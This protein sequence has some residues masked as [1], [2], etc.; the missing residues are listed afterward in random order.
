M[1]CKVPPEMSLRC[2]RSTPR[3]R[4]ARYVSRS[5][6]SPPSSLLS[7]AN[8]RRLLIFDGRT[9]TNSA[10]A[11]G[12][13]LRPSSVRKHSVDH[14]SPLAHVRDR[15]PPRNA[16]HLCRAHHASTPLPAPE[17]P[18]ILGPC[19]KRPTTCTATV[20]TASAAR[21]QPR[22]I[23]GRKGRGGGGAAGG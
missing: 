12:A 6:S 18:L 11:G 7:S 8:A 9:T 20:H 5:S 13:T 14:D 1:H 2:S 23:E 15:V 4:A 21:L 22:E 10:S 16:R 17:L 3:P 19:R